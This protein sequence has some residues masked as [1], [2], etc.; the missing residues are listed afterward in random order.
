MNI[1]ALVLSLQ[2]EVKTNSTDWKFAGVET[3]C[4]RRQILFTKARYAVNLTVQENGQIFSE[5][6]TKS[7][8]DG[9]YNPPRNPNSQYS[10]KLIDCIREADRR[11]AYWANKG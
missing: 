4:R 2:D 8:T 7:N 6:L 1:I 5:I 3:F 9:K 11:I 10:G